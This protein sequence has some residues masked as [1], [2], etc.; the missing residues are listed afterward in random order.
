MGG[1]IRGLLHSTS[2]GAGSPEASG[3][4]VSA[5]R[6]V[7]EQSLW[8]IWVGLSRLGGTCAAESEVIGCTE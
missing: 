7:C 3:L 1:G 5:P 4:R 8:E 6:P 2:K